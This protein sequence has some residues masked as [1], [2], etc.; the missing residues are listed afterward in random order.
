VYRELFGRPYLAELLLFAA[1]LAPAVHADLRAR[2]IP[3][4][5]LLLAGAGLLSLRAARAS[6]SAAQGIGALSAFLLFFVL[7][8][9]A[10]DRMGFGDV[11]LA[12]LVGFLAGFPGW[13]LAAAGASFGGI[14]FVLLRRAIGRRPRDE[15]IAFAPF[16]TVAAVGAA[17]AAPLLEVWR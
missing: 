10:R 13:L 5:S 6:L 16:L 14:A 17:L 8:L 4:F 7:W 11:K 9:A 3:D 15:S 12:G 2:R 1:C